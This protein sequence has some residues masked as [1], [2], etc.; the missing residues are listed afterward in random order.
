MQFSPLIEELIQALRCL[1]G[2]GPKSAQRMALHLLERDRQGGQRL[3][4]VLARAMEQ[5]GHCKNCRTLTEE[6]LCRICS[7]GR[8]NQNVLCV[9][10][11]PADMLALEQSGVYDG[12]YFVLLGHLSPLEGIGPEDLGFD[13]LLQ[14]LKDEPVDEVIL[15]TNP[16][17]EGETTAQYLVELLAGL[18]LKVTHLAHGIPLGGEL[19][20]IDGGTLSRAFAG[21]LGF[22]TRKDSDG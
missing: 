12:R 21:R 14:R 5:V 13:E 3:S 11:T 9:V 17:L 20:F 16:T 15:A 22:A 19:E 8:R 10:E 7:S 1:P 4:S 6:D 18:P 2:V